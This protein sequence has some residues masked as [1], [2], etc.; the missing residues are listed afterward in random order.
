M[1]RTI[2]QTPGLDA[3]HG[4]VHVPCMASKTI[5]L[6]IESYNRLKAAR[7][8]PGESFSSVVQR[9]RWDEALPLSDGRRILEY[10]QELEA[11]GAP[12]YLDEETL[13]TMD[14]RVSRGRTARAETAWDRAGK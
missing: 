4:S 3:K 6:S 7:K 9:A 1:P 5:S 8:H 11:S 14:A 13:D 2:T 12:L 10:Y